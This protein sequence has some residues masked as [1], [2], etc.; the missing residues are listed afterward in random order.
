MACP[1]PGG[2]RP[3]SHKRWSSFRGS[4]PL[5]QARGERSPS[6]APAPKPPR[7]PRPTGTDRTGRSTSGAGRGRTPA[8][9]RDRTGAGPH[10]T[11]EAGRRGRTEARRRGFWGEGEMWR[12]SFVVIERSERLYRDTVVCC[13]NRCQDGPVRREA[14]CETRNDG[15]VAQA[16][17]R[18]PRIRPRGRAPVVGLFAAERRHGACRGRRALG[19][20][21]GRN[22]LVGGQPVP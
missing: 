4:G 17:R 18:G 9:R 10:P 8:A 3:N 16:R 19:G 20:H 14:W 5:W 6:G 13:Q 11:R 7:S 12:C 21:Q 2:T 1:P 22:C 15:S